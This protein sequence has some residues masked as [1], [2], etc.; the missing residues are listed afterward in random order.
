MNTEVAAPPLVRA[1]AEDCLTGTHGKENQANN[2]K[3]R[4]NSVDS[5]VVPRVE[6]VATQQAAADGKRSDSKKRGAQALVM[7][8]ATLTV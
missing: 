2:P 6:F 5:E 4:K 7:K 1:A 8:L 3:G